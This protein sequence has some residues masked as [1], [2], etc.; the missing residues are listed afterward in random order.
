MS[1]L[2][3]AGCGASNWLSKVEVLGMVPSSTKT[4][5]RDSHR[6]SQCMRDGFRFVLK[7][8][9]AALFPSVRSS[10]ESSDNLLTHEAVDEE[11]RKIE[12]EVSVW[13]QQYEEAQ[14]FTAS[15][16]HLDI[17]IS[18][19]TGDL[20]CLDPISSRYH[21]LNKGGCVTSSA[22]TAVRWVPASASL[23]LI[24]HADGT[25]VVYDRD[26]EERAG[27]P[28]VGIHIGIRIEICSACA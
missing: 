28:R 20:I 14:V 21:R 5:C 4:P 23:F 27:C 8:L 1:V 24:S 25:I 3:R 13:R 6:D 10:S 26:R 16:E 18:F 11:N 17:I 19:H 9:N 12:N 7:T 22:C 2:G 15:S